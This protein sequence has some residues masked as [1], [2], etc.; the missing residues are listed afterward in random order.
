M[1]LPPPLLLDLTQANVWRQL[2]LDAPILSSYEAGWQG[3]HLAYHRPS[4]HELPG[5]CFAQHILTICTGSFS[6]QLHRQGQWQKEHYEVGD[7]GIV[8]AHQDGLQALC[9][10]GA[11]F[12]NLYLEPQ[13]L[14]RVAYESVEADSF[15]LV[16]QYKIKDPLIQQIGLALKTELEVGGADSRLYAESMATALS[17][18]LFQRYSTKRSP[19][20]KYSGGLPK[21][22]LRTAIA[23]IQ[24]HLDQELRLADLAALVQISPHYFATLFKQS[25]GVA[26]HQYITQC[27]IDQAKLLLTQRDLAI[28][29]VLLQVGFKSQSHFTRVFRHYT[30]VTPKAYKQMN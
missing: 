24:E 26:P 2:V 5:Y 29:D 15:E 9:D 21:H 30:G 14:A 28:A 25:T 27:R 19:L 7:V 17:A 23:Y 11:E 1:S 13:T 22:K 6:V 18:H 8:P 16:P 12:I 10:R 4:A 20:K 3:L